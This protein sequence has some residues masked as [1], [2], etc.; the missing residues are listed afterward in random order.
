MIVTMRKN[1]HLNSS[2]V[3]LNYDTDSDWIFRV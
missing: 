1:R 2:T 3:N